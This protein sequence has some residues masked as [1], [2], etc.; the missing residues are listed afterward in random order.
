MVDPRFEDESRDRPPPNTEYWVVL[1]VGPFDS[2]SGMDQY[3]FPN[4]AEWLHWQ[5]HAAMLNQG[6]YP[7]LLQNCWYSACFFF[8]NNAFVGEVMSFTLSA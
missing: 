6:I 5:Y 1:M 7:A 2:L 4:N 8:F 3:G